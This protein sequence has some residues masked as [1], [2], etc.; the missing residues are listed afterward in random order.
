MNFLSLVDCSACIWPHNRFNRF[1]ELPTPASTV[2]PSNLL[3]MILKNPPGK[4]VGFCPNQPPTVPGSPA[5]TCRCRRGPSAH[6]WPTHHT[7][8]FVVDFGYR[9]PGMRLQSTSAQD[10][11]VK[12]VRV[13]NEGCFLLRSDEDRASELRNGSIHCA[14]LQ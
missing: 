11:R 13:E 14:S 12:M 8:V 7:F 1:I 2:V 6:S 9:C 5:C 3:L 10:S 4:K